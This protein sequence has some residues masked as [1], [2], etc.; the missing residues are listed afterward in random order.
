M[1][2]TI[3]GFN[4][5][6]IMEAD[7][8]LNDIL[9]LD[10]IIYANGEPKMKHIVQDEISYV[11]LNHEK[12]KEDLPILRYTEGTLRNKLSELKQKGLINSITLAN[13]TTK[14]TMT[15]Y[16]VT[17]KTMSFINDISCNCEVTS[18]NINNNKNVIVSKDTITNGNSE[19]QFGK[20]E[21]KPKKPKVSPNTAEYNDAMFMVTTYTNNSDLKKELIKLVNMKKDMAS[22]ERYKFYASTIKNYLDCLDETFGDDEVLKIEA[23]KLSIRYNGTTKVMIPNST[24]NNKCVDNV[25]SDHKKDYKPAL[26]ENGNPIVF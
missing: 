26:D 25:Q 8:T 16:T 5:K 14:G 19:F 23:I 7:L 10:Y 11:W 12:I 20:V 17:E 24:P 9:L 22:K 3:L 18:N 2:Y 21:T 13:K 15:Y 1:K 4:Q 6:L